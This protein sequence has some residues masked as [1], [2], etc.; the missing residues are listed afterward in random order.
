MVQTNFEKIVIGTA[1]AIAASA[2]LP[3]A[4]T[5]FRPI[6]EAGMQGGTSLLNR[7]KSYLQLAREE[8][9]DIIAEA[10]FERMKK[11]LDQEIALLDDTQE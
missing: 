9:E 11:Q 2:L 8:V 3:I 5:T 4:K 6:A 7:G 10:K 1:L